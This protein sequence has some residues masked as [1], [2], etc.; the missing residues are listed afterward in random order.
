MAGTRVFH[1]EVRRGTDADVVTGPSGVYRPLSPADSASL[2]QA[3]AANPPP[4]A[5]WQEIRHDAEAAA[6]AAS[7]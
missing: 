3:L 1:Q 2:A 4:D 7:G 5:L 6:V